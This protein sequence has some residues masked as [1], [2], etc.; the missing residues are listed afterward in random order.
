[1]KILVAVIAY[2][3]EGNIEKV[4][5]D[6]IANNFGYDIV[7]I[8]N[9]SL[10]NTSKLCRKFNITLISHCTNTG[11]FNG[12]FLSYFMYANSNNYDIVCQF[13]GDGQHLATELPKIIDPL[14]SGIADVVIGSRFIKREGFQSY[15][16]RRIGIKVFSG[17]IS[18][19]TGNRF[20]D[21]TSGFRSYNRKIIEYFGYYS[22]FI[23][24]DV[25]HEFILYT[26]YLGG[27]FIEVPVL[28][29]S[30]EQGKSE[31]NIWNALFFPVKSMISILGSILRKKQIQR[32]AR[33]LV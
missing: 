5:E 29:K 27:K 7:V 2:N 23:V 28:M 15:F 11:G 17:I 3:E 1:M 30:R 19:I 24:H 9:G 31:F 4:I 20:T 13:D 25:V 18:S 10:D 6:L 12:A 16:F 8:D 33:Y 32:K 26:H 22:N 14:V 21:I